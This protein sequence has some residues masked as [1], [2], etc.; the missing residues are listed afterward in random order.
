[1]SV[2]TATATATPATTALTPKPHPAA[3]RTVLSELNPLQYIPVVGALYRAV[4]G[5]TIPE[6][7]REAGSL[8][9]S[10]LTGGP[11]GVASN[12]ALLVG[13]KITGID[14]EKTEKAI[15]ASVGIGTPARQPPAATPSHPPAKSPAPPQTAW[16]A[17]QLAAYGVTSA[18][19][20]I[21]RGDLTGS[22]V[23]N[24]LELGR[25]DAKEKQEAVLF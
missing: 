16:S 13:E 9:V 14:V 22:D 11:I 8:V 2:P 18:Q 21:R 7:T 5:D 4:T 6:P 24:E 10:F 17:A 1:M 25:I 12:L 23:L 20:T 19:G 15:F 3:F